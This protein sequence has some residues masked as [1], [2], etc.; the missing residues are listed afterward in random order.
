MQHNLIQSGLSRPTIKEKRLEMVNADLIRRNSSTLDDVIEA[1]KSYEISEISSRLI[2]LHAE[3]DPWRR[4]KRDVTL[5]W[6]KY[7]T[8]GVETKMVRGNHIT[9]V[10]KPYIESL[11]RT[12]QSYLSRFSPPTVAVGE[13]KNQLERE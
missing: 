3:H 4:A 13:E 7:A 2:L 11:G 6:G 5:G 1:G 10:R 8:K 12:L 9:M